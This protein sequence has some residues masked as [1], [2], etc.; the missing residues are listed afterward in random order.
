MFDKRQATLASTEIG[1]LFVMSDNRS[2]IRN[3][4]SEIDDSLGNMPLV[5]SLTYLADLQTGK[6]ENGDS[7]WV[8]ARNRGFDAIWAITSVGQTHLNSPSARNQPEP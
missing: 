4:R 3:I 1:K 6:R 5:V 7:V 8:E 2:C